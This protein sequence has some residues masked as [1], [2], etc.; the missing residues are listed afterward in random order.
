MFHVSSLHPAVQM[1]LAWIFEHRD[2][3]A[4]ASMLLG[5]T[6]AQRRTARFL[7]ELM[8]NGEMTRR[9]LSDLSWLHGLL[10]LER[11]ADPDT[12]EAICFA[13]INPEDPVVYEICA[14]AD[15]LADRLEPVRAEHDR[16]GRFQKA[17]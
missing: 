4:S 1:L 7:E 17:A 2:A 3:L 15:G 10:T 6:P 8:N 9:I 5:G 16:K 11:V 13:E 12:E 14:L